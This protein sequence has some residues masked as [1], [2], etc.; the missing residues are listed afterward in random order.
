MISIADRLYDQKMKTNLLP[1]IYAVYVHVNWSALQMGLYLCMACHTV[2]WR[3]KK[4]CRLMQCICTRREGNRTHVLLDKDA[5][6]VE[7]FLIFPDVKI[8]SLQRQYGWQRT[9]LS[10]SLS[11]CEMRRHEIGWLTAA[12]F[13]HSFVSYFCLS[14]PYLTLIYQFTGYK[15]ATG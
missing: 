7:L 1:V 4:N 8:P 9:P 15:I 3:G 14:V 10:L 11:L 13:D 12:C 6:H 5:L 2:Q